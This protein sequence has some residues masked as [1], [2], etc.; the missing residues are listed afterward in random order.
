M[1]P[2]DDLERID[3]LIFGVGPWVQGVEALFPLG[4]KVLVACVVFQDT[5]GIR[6]ALRF[7]QVTLDNR[8]YLDYEPPFLAPIS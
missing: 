7:L 2:I 6:P 3:T 8:F 5:Q 1:F 4:D